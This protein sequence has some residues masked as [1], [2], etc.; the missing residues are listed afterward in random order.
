MSEIAIAWVIFLQFLHF[1][2]LSHLPIGVLF[3]C[4]GARKVLPWR[5]TVHLSGTPTKVTNLIL[6][7]LNSYFSASCAFQLVRSGTAEIM[8][9]KYFHCLKQ[10]VFLLYGSTR[11][12][13]SLSLQSH[14][15][16]WN[17][18]CQC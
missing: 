5:L 17:G 10:A 18:I 1:Y 12:F 16:M 6:K 7:P 11:Y 4:C 3:D 15:D 9:N 14:T 8:Q 13:T 2:V